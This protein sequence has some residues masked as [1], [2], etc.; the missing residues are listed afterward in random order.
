[1]AEAAYGN[2]R[3]QVGN[4]AST[5]TFTT[6]AGIKSFDGPNTELAFIETTDFDSTGGFREFAPT[7]KD[8]GTLDLTLNF[9][10]DSVTHESMVTDHDAKTLRNFKLRLKDAATDKIWSFAGYFASV[11]VRA[12]VDGLSECSV[13]IRIS[14]AINR[15]AT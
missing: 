6:L 15:D 8:P 1:M 11:G 3:L 2:W 5:E 12:E 7:L 10:P 14:G 13:S 4:G 9:E